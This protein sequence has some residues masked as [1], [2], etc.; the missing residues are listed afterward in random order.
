MTTS[1]QRVQLQSR[2]RGKTAHMRTSD[3]GS[4]VEP[5]S[6]PVGRLPEGTA[7]KKLLWKEVAKPLTTTGN[8]SRKTT[9]RTGGRKQKIRDGSL[10]GPFS[11]IRAYAISTTCVLST[12]ATTDST[13][14]GKREATRSRVARQCPREVLS[15]RQVHPKF[16]LC[17]NGV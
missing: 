10:C 2:N 12:S 17:A 13:S 8:F 11:V 5:Q 16:S 14:H 15:A 6:T 3:L 9:R 4:N 7:G 1:E